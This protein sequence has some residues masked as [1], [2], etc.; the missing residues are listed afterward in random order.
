MIAGCR[1]I[2][3]AFRFPDLPDLPDLRDITHARPH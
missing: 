1:P 2:S 3:F